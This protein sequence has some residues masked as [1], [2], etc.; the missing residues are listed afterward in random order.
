VRHT[1]SLAGGFRRIEKGGGTP[2]TDGNFSPDAE[3][4][5][6]AIVNPLYGQ[7]QIVN[8][9]SGDASSGMVVNEQTAIGVSA[10]FACVSFLS[11]M[12]AK[13]PIELYQKTSKGPKQI[14]NHKAIRLIGAMPNEMHTSFELRQLMMTGKGLGGNG[15]ARVFRD[16]YGE[17]TAIEWVPPYD[18][19]PQIIQRPNGQKIVTYQV[20]GER[21]PLTRYDLIHI[22]DLTRDGVN[23]VS[24]ITLLRE[25][26]GTAIS[27]TKAAGKLM[28]NGTQFPG[29]LTV[30]GNV[31]AEQLAQIR[32]EFNEK[33][34]GSFNTGRIPV[35]GGA[36][37]FKQTNGMSMSDAQFIESRRFELQEIARHYRIPPFLI[38]DSTA[39]TTW[40]TGIEQQTLGFLNFTLDPH[41]K[42][43]EEALNYTLL[44][45]DEVDR[46]FYFRFD[47]DELAGVSRQD[48]AN[49]FMQMRNMGVYSVNDI[50]AKLD[51]PRIS[52]E[53]GGD[54]YA[55]PLNSS[56]K[57]A[58]AP[59]QEPAPEPVE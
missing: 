1:L 24:P 39:S 26:I 11:D 3:N 22:R 10:V 48:T 57:A 5:N 52:P 59:A 4:R 14:K 32:D 29:Y 50:R 41:L 42:A 54:N 35:L 36:V 30:Q 19:R 56:A 49:Y 43:F 6:L 21:G 31:K 45:T 18:V 55:L 2:A 51:E 34:A 20:T 37:D 16:V 23:G 8:V 28:K 15:Y 46:G 7:S 58:P 44:T 40:G 53:D 9:L 33:Y 25:S 38:G 12:V 27:Q 47:R 13:L 17:P